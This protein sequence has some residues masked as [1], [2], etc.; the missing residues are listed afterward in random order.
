MK[1]LWTFEV[2]NF[3][4]K[5]ENDFIIS[6]IF[7]KL[8]KILSSTP[9]PAA[10]PL[11]PTRSEHRL[12]ATHRRYHRPRP[13]RHGLAVLPLASSSADRRRR[14]TIELARYR[15]N[16]HR[17]DPSIPVMSD[18]ATGQVFLLSSQSIYPLWWIFKSRLVEI[19]SSLGSLDRP[20]CQR[21]SRSL[22]V[23]I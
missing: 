12:L 14:S 10:D 23:R 1:N 16:P 2:R 11:D 15:W 18:H 9:D 21:Q 20:M 7:R 17:S 4:Y 13:T 22:S 19:G 6:G 3:F 8:P 5:Y